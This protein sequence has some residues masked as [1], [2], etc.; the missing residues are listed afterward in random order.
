MRIERDA[1]GARVTQV[2][3][4]CVDTH[5]ATDEWR[6]G[7]CRLPGLMGRYICLQ[8]T[9][10][11]AY[12][13]RCNLYL[14]PWTYSNSYYIYSLRTCILVDYHIHTITSVLNSTRTVQVR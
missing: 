14:V 12:L 10:Y 6:S 2:C 11:I 1:G 3:E 8:G 13:V 5:T 9:S 4:C 7:V